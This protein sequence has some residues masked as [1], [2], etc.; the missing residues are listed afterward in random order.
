MKGALALSAVRALRSLPT[1]SIIAPGS[2]IHMRKDLPRAYYIY[3]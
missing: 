1:R 3:A 2:A